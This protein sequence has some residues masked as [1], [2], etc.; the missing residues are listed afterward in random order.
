LT[1]NE[2]ITRSDAG[3]I[4]TE[5]PVKSPV[6]VPD[7]SSYRPEDYEPQYRWQGEGP[8]PRRWWAADG[9]LVYRSYAD[10]CDD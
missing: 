1:E 10:Y 8:P 4:G 9:T 6:S 5:S 3:L 7:L 2:S